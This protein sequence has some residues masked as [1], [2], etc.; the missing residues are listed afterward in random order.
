MG[1]MFVVVSVGQRVL[2]KPEGLPAI[3]AFFTPIVAF[4]ATGI[5]LAMLMLMPAT[6]APELGV[7]LG[8]LGIAGLGYMFASGAHAAWRQSDLAL[9]DWVWYVALPFLSYLAICGGGLAIGSKIATGFYVVGG[10]SI[11]LLVIGIRNAW[12]LVVYISQRSEE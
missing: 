2:G 11:L 8:I 10:A 1:L 4:F 7:L 3:R 9:D 5:V 12:D 6:S